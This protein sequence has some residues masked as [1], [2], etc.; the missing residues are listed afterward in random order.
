MDLVRLASYPKSGSTWL[1]AVLTNYLRD[2][3]EPAAINALIGRPLAGDRDAFDETLRLESSDRTQDEVL[4]Y[5]PL[6]YI[7]PA[8]LLQEER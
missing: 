5:R 7:P 1:R 6:P 8:P 4:R 2:D 3:A